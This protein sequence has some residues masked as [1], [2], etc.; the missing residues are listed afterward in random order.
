[1]LCFLTAQKDQNIFVLVILKN[2]RH[3]LLDISKKYTHV[4]F[5]RL[6]R[7]AGSG[8]DLHLFQ[9][10]FVIG[11][12]NSRDDDITMPLSLKVIGSAGYRD[13]WNKRFGRLLVNRSFSV[14][15]HGQ[16]L[17]KLLGIKESFNMWKEFNSQMIF[18][19]TQT[20]PPI[21]FFVH[22]NGRR[23]VMWKRSIVIACLYNLVPRFLF[24]SG[25]E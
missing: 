9:T 7:Q 3:Y 17:C 21:F 2:K 24:L 13:Q 20:W 6:F 25:G 18:F 5:N 8:A 23:D 12:E 22:N 14:T 11:W 10:R 19:Y 16:Q 4:L 15:W 1:M